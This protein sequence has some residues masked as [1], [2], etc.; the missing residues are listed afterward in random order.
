[1]TSSGKPPP[2]TTRITWAILRQKRFGIANRILR[3]FSRW[4]Q[5]FMLEKLLITRL[6]PRHNFTLRRLYPILF[7]IWR[8]QILSALSQP[9]KQVGANLITK[10]LPLDRKSTTR[11]VAPVSVVTSKSILTPDRPGA[12]SDQRTNTR[13]FGTSPYNHRTSVCPEPTTSFLF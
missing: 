3:H 6:I 1:M 9:T 4:L 12:Y 10:T 2:G 5:T 7:P 8:R 11:S 13:H